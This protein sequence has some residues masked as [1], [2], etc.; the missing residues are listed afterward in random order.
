MDNKLTILSL[1]FLFISSY[2]FA[3]TIVLKSG[4]TIKGKILEKTDS[5]I[6]VDIAG[7]PI[8]YYLD[9]IENIDGVVTNKA[10]KQ[11]SSPQTTT[12][13]AV[14]SSIDTEQI[15]S[16]LKHLGYPK[17]TWPDIERE[18]VAFLVKINFPALKNE[19]IQIKSDTVEKIGNF[20]EKVG[21]LIYQEANIDYPQPHILSKLMVNSL[22][23]EDMIQVINA[24]PMDQKIK[25]ERIQKEIFACSAISQLGSIIL[26]LLQ[27]KV[28]VAE[29]PNHIF[30]CIV[31][32]EGKLLYILDYSLKVFGVVDINKYYEPKGKYLVLKEE[33]WLSPE[34]LCAIEEKTKKGT[35]ITLGELL[36]YRYHS[37]Y[38]TGDYSA[39]RTIYGNCGYE[40]LNK[41]DYEKALSSY[42]K[43]IELGPNDPYAYFNRGFFYGKINKCREA[44]LDFNKSIELYPDF[45]EAYNDRGII[46]SFTN[47]PD[48]AITDF[49]K[50]IEIDKAFVLPYYNRANAY[51]LKQEYN[52]AWE[53]LHKAES[54]GFKGESTFL[55]KLKQAS[56][57]EK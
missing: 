36:E 19:L 29:T 51:F 12:A 11:I 42:N 39:T 1:I 15:H 20:L 45:A 8:T 37:I 44:I 50:A 40:Y 31:F 3:E 34:Q 48:L 6:K 24:S 28:E 47:N 52:K 16:M 9:E 23:G 5:S 43:A 57:R 53:D 38:I 18:L 4:K 56:G 35:T 22:A 49:N 14:M 46:Y 32:G 30:N 33:Y 55:E 25:E 27:F 26:N 41:G 21:R 2:V 7:I 10:E 13:D 17:D 54:L